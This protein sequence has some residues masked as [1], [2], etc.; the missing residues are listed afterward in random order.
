M[1]LKKQNVINQRECLV[2][3]ETLA[4]SELLR[5]VTSPSGEVVYD[6]TGKLPARGMWI[7]ADKDVLEKALKQNL[8]SKRS[9]SSVS[10]IVTKEEILEQLKHYI[11]SL[12]QLANKAGLVFFGQDRIAQHLDKNEVSALII[13]QDSSLSSRNKLQA[14]IRSDITQ[15]DCFNSSDMEEFFSSNLVS[16][17]GLKSGR[18]TDNIIDKSLLYAKLQ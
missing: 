6:V 12:V 5:F 16:F 9:K 11:F 15:I 17:I 2:T 3:R 10:K 7:K 14:H 1:A 4:K 13:S 18:M 8:L